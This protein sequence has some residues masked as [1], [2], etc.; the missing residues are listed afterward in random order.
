MWQLLD[1]VLGKDGLYLLGRD[2]SAIDMFLVMLAHWSRKMKKP[3]H[4]Y[5]HLRRLM[6]LIEARPA[7]RRMMTEE[8]NS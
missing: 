7:Y 8:G 6:E 1:G 2:F 4:S 3:A 5:P